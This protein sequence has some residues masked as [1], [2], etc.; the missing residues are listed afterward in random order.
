[1]YRYGGQT[2]RERSDASRLRAE[3]D[4]ARSEITAI[5]AKLDKA[6]GDLREEKGQI[7][8]L[9]TSI[10][11]LRTTVQVQSET[12][13]GSK[14]T[15]NPN[16]FGTGYVHTEQGTLAIHQSNSGLVPLSQ[17]QNPFPN[18][19]PQDQRQNFTTGP[20]PHGQRQSPFPGPALVN[21]P[22]NSAHVPMPYASNSATHSSNWRADA[23]GPLTQTRPYAEP[24]AMATQGQQPQEQITWSTEFSKF[25]KL[26]EEW[27]RNYANS[28]N[29]AKDLTLPDGL[30][31]ALANNSHSDQVMGLISSAGTRYL[32]VARMVNSWVGNDL[33]QPHVLKQ[34]SHSFDQ[35]VRRF[36]EGLADPDVPVS[37]RQGLLR[38]IADTAKELTSTDDFDAFVEHHILEEVS[39]LWDRLA[40]LFAS[41][42]SQTQAW[43]DLQHIFREGFR[44]AVLMLCTPLSYCFTYPSV[45]RNSY[46]N[47]GCMINRDLTYKDNPLMLLRRGLRVRLGIT[48]VIVTTSYVGP[49]IVPQTVHL[50]NVLLMQ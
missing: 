48:P 34:Y 27:A 1:M 35:K 11:Q 41:G 23:M 24:S 17:R 4:E 50:A 7:S 3:R 44:I 32:L 36:R 42:I 9:Q 31:K 5:K 43:A 13:K 25:F 14:E 18:P 29:R 30:L 15:K 28:P 8:H 16:R 49:S 38:V 21:Q 40:Y 2:E 6:E 12:I 45:D 22:S 37:V 47:P 26:T 10:G 46:F 20:A 19:S 33:F 39:S